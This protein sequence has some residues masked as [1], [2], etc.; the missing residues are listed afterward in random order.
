MDTKTNWKPEV[1]GSLRAY[2]CIELEL[3]AAGRLATNF[4]IEKHSRVGHDGRAMLGLQ[5]ACTEVWCSKSNLRQL[6]ELIKKA[7]NHSILT[8]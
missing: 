2:I 7:A 1:L 6:V 4:D 3:D 5:S 8:T